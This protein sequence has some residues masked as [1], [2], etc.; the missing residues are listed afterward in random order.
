MK[1]PLSLQFGSFGRYVCGMDHFF[2]L[3]DFER[4]LVVVCR[5]DCSYLC[6]WMLT[7]STIK[8]QLSLQFG[9][10]TSL[11]YIVIRK[12]HLLIKCQVSRVNPL[13]IRSKAMFPLLLSPSNSPIVWFLRKLRIVPI[14]T[15]ATI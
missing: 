1:D 12:C 15:I 10:G 5:V 14:H 3:M 11:P 8:D 4:L 7:R 6:F 13:F 2:L 9:H